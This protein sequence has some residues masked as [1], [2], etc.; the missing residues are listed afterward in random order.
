MRNRPLEPRV[1]CSRCIVVLQPG[2]LISP[3][4]RGGKERYWVKTPVLFHTRSW[5]K[6]AEDA[7]AA[8]AEALERLERTER[9][10]A[11]RGRALDA[12]L[13][14]IRAREAAVASKC[15]SVCWSRCFSMYQLRVLWSMITPHAVRL[16][17]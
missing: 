16:R 6:A 11:E 1:R 5:R 8:A 17:L 15:A 14:D 7:E 3:L 12:R 2:K 10:G 13:R 9:Q 4:V